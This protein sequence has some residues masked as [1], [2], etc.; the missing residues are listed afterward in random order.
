MG[1]DMNKMRERMNSL[2]NN[3]NTRKNNFGSQRRRAD[4]SSCCTVRW[5]TPSAITAHHDVAGEP[6]FLS[7]KRNFGG[8]LST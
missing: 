2:K 5:L 3:G 1:I 6:G 8:G 7:P 4:H